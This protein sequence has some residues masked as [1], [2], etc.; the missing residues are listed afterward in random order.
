MAGKKKD[1]EKSTSTT[2]KNIAGGS[3]TETENKKYGKVEEAVSCMLRF[4]DETVKKEHLGNNLFQLYIEDQLR[5]RLVGAD[6]ILELKLF[7]KKVKIQLKECNGE[8]I[9]QSE[10]D[11]EKDPIGYLI[12]S[13]TKIFQKIFEEDFQEQPSTSSQTQ[14]I[15]P[16]QE[17]IIDYDI[18]SYEDLRKIFEYQS[19]YKDIP[20]TES[21]GYDSISNLKIKGVLL[22]GTSGT[23]KTFLIK[24]LIQNYPHLK[25]LEF[26]QKNFDK[27]ETSDV[28]AKFDSLNRAIFDNQTPNSPNYDIIV[29][30]NINLK[31][32]ESNL[33]NTIPT[34][35]LSIESLFS[36]IHNTLIIGISNNLENIPSELRKVNLFEK[37]VYMDN[38]NPNS[39]LKILSELLNQC[40][41]QKISSSDL[42]TLSLKMSGFS[43]SDI[44]RYIKEAVSISKIQKSGT[45][46]LEILKEAL[47]EIQPTQLTEILVEMPKVYWKDIGGYEEVKRT[48]KNVVELPQ[49]RPEIF[50]KK[51]VSPSKGIQ[52]YGPPGCSKTLMAKAI[53]TEGYFNFLSVKGPEIFSKYVGDSEKA[54][55]DIFRK[56]RLSAPCVIFFDEIDSIA[57]KRGKS[58][59][60]SDRVLI[61]L[62]TE[63][64]GFDGLKD[65]LVLAATNRPDS[66]DAAQIRPGRFDEL[67][68]ISVPDLEARKGILEIAMRNMP[69]GE[70]VDLVKLGDKTEGYTGAEIVNICREAGLGSI[71]RDIES[72]SVDWADFE[73]ALDKVK[74][75]VT[76]EVIESYRNF[77]LNKK[78]LF[79]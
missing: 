44:Y 11:V 2:N 73:C 24:R 67:V 30:D 12:S 64:D 56:A 46:T 55:R 71:K 74:K 76:K 28:V 33:S 72:Q 13:K 1:K 43:I 23:G 63:M 7:G 61:Q 51:G 35:I 21:Q 37:C 31:N 26:S 66:Q 49:L 41:H 8:S 40:Q 15:L 39:R 29:F 69:L 59:E 16:K 6:E 34:I 9:T 14:K 25:V 70:D 36:K 5:N 20:I 77:E 57:G 62:L 50:T 17:F 32:S 68:H 22:T 42:T 18:K 54:I 19:T 60:V 65:I 47:S 3:S 52:F 48:V 45:I 38:P 10:P 27:I 53:A 79:G 4:C 58:T 75:R 78:S